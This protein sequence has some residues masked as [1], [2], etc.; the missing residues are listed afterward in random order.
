MPSRGWDRRR[1]AWCCR[2][3]RDAAAATMGLEAVIND[4]NGNLAVIEPLGYLDMLQLLQHATA[5]L[6]DSGGMQK[7]A[8]YLGVPLPYAPRRNGMGRDG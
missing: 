5:I 7:E 1:A 3:T 2:C 4:R 6:T 8:Y